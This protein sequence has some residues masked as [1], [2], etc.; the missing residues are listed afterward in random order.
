[1]RRAAQLNPPVA[2]IIP[3]TAQ[4]VAVVE[5]SP[6]SIRSPSVVSDT[7][8]STSK[9]SF[10]K[11]KSISNESN[12]EPSPSAAS[13]TASTNKANNSSSQKSISTVTGH[14]KKLSLK[15]PSSIDNKV[16]SHSPAVRKVAKTLVPLV[17]RQGDEDEVQQPESSSWAATRKTNKPAGTK[18][19]SCMENIPPTDVAHL[20]CDHGYCKPCILELFKTSLVDE[21]LFPPRCCQK[22]IHPDDFKAF[23][24]TEVIE[25]YY[26][27]KQELETMDRT[28]CS[29]PSCS[30]FMRPENITGDSATCPDCKKVTCTM[31]KASF[32]EGECPVDEGLQKIL[33]LAKEAGWQRCS[34]CK[35][36][37]SITIGCNHMKFVALT[38]L[39]SIFPPLTCQFVQVSLQCNVVL[40]M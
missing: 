22:L 20:S 39:L 15:L 26:R 30:V 34:T 14:N 8:S 25:S 27:K 33:E 19:A 4:R 24:A 1:M 6:P 11:G 10:Q 13:D 31:C 12:D 29:N 2:R 16:T 21:T 38:P 9:S 23:L 32:H 28:Y 5:I 18:C 37:V 7:A 3:S 36:M 17:I 40:P 35:A